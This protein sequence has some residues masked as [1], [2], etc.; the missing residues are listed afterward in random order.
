MAMNAWIIELPLDPC[1]SRRGVPTPG[2]WLL[3]LDPPRFTDITR[4]EYWLT[5]Y[6][7]YP[8]CASI[9]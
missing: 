9:V 6:V 2:K 8:K 3:T 5:V 1:G 4:E 7:F